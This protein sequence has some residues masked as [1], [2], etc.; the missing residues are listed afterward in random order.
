MAE[1][2]NSSTHACINKN[3]GCKVEYRDKYN[4]A[5]NIKQHQ[6]YIDGLNSRDRETRLS[7]LAILAGGIRRGEVNRPVAGSDVNNHIHTTYSFS[8]YS[9]SKAVWTAYN[10]GLCT[11]GIMDHDSVGGADEFTEA[12]IIIG[13]AT[14]IGI[15]CRVNMASTELKGRR[16]NNPDQESVMYMAI[17]GIPH[18]RIGEVEKFI[19]PYRNERNKRNR[20]MIDRINSIVRPAGIFVD[21]DNDVVPLSMQA[22]GGSITERH[23]LFAL[24]LKLIRT[25][26]KGAVIPEYL[27]N[28]LR[29]GISPKVR[30][31]LED[32]SNIYYEY[33]L[34]GALKSSMVEMFYIDAA[35][36]CPDV[37]ETVGFAAGIGA[38]SA[39]AY[40]GD[41][42]DSVTGD[43]KTQKFEDDYIDLLFEVIMK[44]GFKAVTYM[45]SRNT[46]D[47]LKKI[48]ALCIEN[49]F[50]QISGEDINSPR[51]KFI[52]EA[53]RNIEYSNL[54]ESTYA[55]IGHEYLATADNSKAFFSD[56]TIIEYPDINDRIKVYAETGREIK[57]RRQA[58]AGV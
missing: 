37:R 11:A 52:C 41:V 7:S 9:P 10:A 38:I 23:L 50:M 5:Y 18:N 31:F 14:T 44:A 49:G 47:Q 48:K 29:L 53:L 24:S 36:E 1:Y 26:G 19:M 35:A 58:D 56:R 42:G 45:P 20:L 6:E 21:F 25:F 22:D 32:P 4:G 17:H 43:K 27:E 2:L 12:G 54:I 16:I 40:L 28:E 15:E 3:G 55:L 34:L 13:M 8:P 30:T 39:Y 46:T 51:Q 57:R 33:D